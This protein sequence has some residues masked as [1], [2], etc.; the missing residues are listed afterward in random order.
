MDPILLQFLNSTDDSESDRLLQQLVCEHA[1][2]LIRQIVR[3]KLTKGG[4]AREYQETD[5]EDIWGDIVV[6]VI[7]RLR[8]SKS[9][10]NGKQIG[11][12]RNYIAAMSYNA[13][14]DHL[15]RKYPQRHSLKNKL[16]YVLNHDE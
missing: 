2:P 6:K 16:R 15:R 7:K 10:P 5:F 13:C 12:L 9:D 1:E 8:E 3:F 11:N 4:W 14:D